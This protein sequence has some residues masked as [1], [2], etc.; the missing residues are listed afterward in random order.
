MGSGSAVFFM[1]SGIR[2]TTNFAVQGSEFLSFLGSGIKILGKNMGSVTKEY[3]SL[4]PR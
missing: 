3:T 4:R 1:K 2:L